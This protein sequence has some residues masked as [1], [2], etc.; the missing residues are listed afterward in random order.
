MMDILTITDEELEQV[1]GGTFTPNSYSAS[2]YHQF[3]ISTSYNIIYK[4][5]FKFMGHS[6]SYERANEIMKIGND[7]MCSLNSGFDHKNKI[8]STENAF[9]RAFNYQLSL[10]FGRDYMWNGVPGTNF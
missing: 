9:I 8:G 10:R 6:I 7:V 2:G 5:E 1:T 4:D 3:G